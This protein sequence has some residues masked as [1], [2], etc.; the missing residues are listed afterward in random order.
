MLSQALLRRKILSDRFN[1]L[2]FR[3]GKEHDIFLV[4]GYIRD[5][6]RGSRARDRD[7]VVGTNIDMF[8]ARICSAVP[9]TM[10]TFKKGNV[11]RLILKNGACFDFTPLR[12]TLKNDL[13]QRDF[14]INALAWSA[15][16][17]IIDYHEGADD[18]AK[19]VIRAI[20]KNNLVADPLRILRAYRFA[21][22]LNGSIAL[23]TRN[24]IKTINYK[25]K[26]ASPERIT[27]EIFHLL[28]QKNAARYL[29]NALDDSVLQYIFP[30]NSR[31]SKKNI[32][33]ISELEYRIQKDPYR[34]FQV[35]LKKN[36]SQNLTYKGLLCLELL[37]MPFN[38]EAFEKARLA[39]SKKILRRLHSF[40]RGIQCFDC[41]EY[42][43]FEKLFQVFYTANE[44]SPDILLA[45][46]MT[47]VMPEYRRYL[48][49][50]KGGRI[51]TGFLQ[52]ISGIADGRTFGEILRE[53]R[54]AE[55]IGNIKTKEETKRFIEQTYPELARSK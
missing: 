28:N 37:C 7:F 14:S 16:E 19:D 5:L 43:G 15:S 30:Y 17:G 13:A 6:I 52:E 20:S 1:A 46:N 53:T 18:I 31:Y 9:A 40:T 23:E 27:L 10:V 34:I 26:T 25:I 21:A 51:P 45:K 2:V 48:S 55:F 36:Y 32:E 41:K 35:K 12:G 44:A 22:E 39:L 50:W 33:S 54:K 42:R 29:K 3:A 11:T 8:L 38:A 4:G 47:S 49:I 24:A